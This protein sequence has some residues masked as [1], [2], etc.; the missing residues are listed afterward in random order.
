[1]V[2]TDYPSMTTPLVHQHVADAAFYWQVAKEVLCL[3]IQPLTRWP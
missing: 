3:I 1:M 2:T